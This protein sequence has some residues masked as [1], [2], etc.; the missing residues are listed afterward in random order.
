MATDN[1]LIRLIGD[2]LVAGFASQGVTPVPAI[3]Q[4][5][6]PTQQGA[7]SGPACYLF[8][9][10]DHRYGFPKK[11]QVWNTITEV[12]DDA[13]VQVYETTFQ[14]EC[15]VT[16]TPAS[17]LTASDILNVASGVLQAPKYQALMIAQGV[18]ILR[19]TD[20]RNPYFKND[21]DQFQ[22]SPSFDFTLTHHRS[23]ISTTPS[24]SPVES[25]I[26]RV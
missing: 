15:L 17:T 2:I 12:F 7:Q 3:R 6:Q 4:A 20:V 16:L 19:V 25:A 23:I 14:C 11:G 10:S 18:N 24:A 1:Q 9:V 21:M 22:A 8:K 5:Y 13:T 26:Y